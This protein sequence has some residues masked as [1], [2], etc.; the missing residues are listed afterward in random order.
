ML[1]AF[2]CAEAQVLVVAN[3]RR[4]PRRRLA[5]D[6]DWVEVA[7]K[8]L[9]RDQT[10]LRKRDTDGERDRVLRGDGAGGASKTRG[11][12]GKMGGRGWVG[13]PYKQPAQT[14]TSH[15]KKNRSFRRPTQQLVK[16]Q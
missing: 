1:V 4:Q 10:F 15:K 14:P 16:G 9:G 13:T 8:E 11:W 6:E 2:A 3:R 5:R 7:A 12:G